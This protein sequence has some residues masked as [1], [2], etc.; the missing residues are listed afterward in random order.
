MLWFALLSKKKN[1]MVCTVFFNIY[2]HQP[3]IMGPIFWETCKEIV[4][5]GHMTK[6]FDLVTRHKALPISFF[7]FF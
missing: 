2:R 7:F 1:V 5:G 3:P 6:K 4:L